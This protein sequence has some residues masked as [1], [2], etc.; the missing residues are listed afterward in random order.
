MIFSSFSNLEY[1]QNILNLNL[2]KYEILKEENIPEGYI[3]NAEFI[4]FSIAD[5]EL[6]INKQKLEV[7]PSTGSVNFHPIIIICLS[8]FYFLIKSGKQYE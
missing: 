2:F 8:I 3:I 6:I 1:I 5:E 4:P 7:L